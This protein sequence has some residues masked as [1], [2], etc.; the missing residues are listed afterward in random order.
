MKT[1]TRPQ[2]GLALLAGVG[3]RPRGA[4]GVDRKPRRR[5][6]S[7]RA[8]RLGENF[9]DANL[10]GEDFACADLRGASFK[11]AKLRGANLRGADL[12]EANLAYADVF[13]ADPSGANLSGGGSRVVDACLPYRAALT[14]VAVTRFREGASSQGLAH[15][16]PRVGVATASCTV[17]VPLTRSS[18]N[19]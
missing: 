14:G 15:S 3:P 4:V 13:A 10:R 2:Q 1:L 6:L 5:Y 8:R 18:S 17:E 19:W 12:R 7:R 11:Y 9:D 16:R